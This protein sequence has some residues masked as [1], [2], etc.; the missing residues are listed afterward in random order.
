M[1]LGGGGSTNRRAD[2]LMSFPCGCGLF[3]GLHDGDL[4]G[5]L[6]HD[7]RPAVAILHH[8][9]DADRRLLE[10]LCW[11]LDAVGLQPIEST[12]EDHHGE[13]LLVAVVAAGVEEA[14]RLAGQLT[15]GL[16]DELDRAF[17]A[18]MGERVGRVDRRDGRLGDGGVGG[19]GVPRS[20]EKI[21]E[22]E[23]DASILPMREVPGCEAACA[24]VKAAAGR[25]SAGPSRLP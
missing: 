11:A 24:R 16:D 8:A 1:P 21:S 18:G 6:D 22:R 12:L 5:L 23:G 13:V 10:V 20:D 19:A 7:L 15:G 17:L 25:S 14:D 9:T 4:S 3:G 2:A